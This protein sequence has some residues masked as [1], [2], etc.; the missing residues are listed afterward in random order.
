MVESAERGQ[1]LTADCQQEKRIVI[2]PSEVK[3]SRAMPRPHAGV[4]L[5]PSFHLFS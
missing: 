4:I 5:F 1:P 2:A 3:G